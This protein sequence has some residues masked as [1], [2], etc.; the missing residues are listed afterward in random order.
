MGYV[1]KEVSSVREVELVAGA[2]PAR[3]VVWALVVVAVA[4]KG[5]VMEAEVVL[6]VAAS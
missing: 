1:R 4:V 6:V 2:T 5:G 3:E